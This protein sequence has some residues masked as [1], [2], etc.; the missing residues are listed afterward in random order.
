MKFTVLMPVHDAIGLNIFK[1][2]INSVINNILV[3]SEFLIIVDGK[4][5]LKKRLFLLKEKKRNKFI[6]VIFKKKL[7][8]VKILNFGLKI[9]K[10]NLVARADADDL[11]HKNRFLE[12]VNFF[13]KNKVDILGSNINEIINRKKFIKKVPT[14]P[15][16]LH[17]CFINPINHN[18]VMFRKDKIMRLGS[19]PNIKY[20]EDY[21]LWFLAKLSGYIVRNLDINLVNSVFDINKMIRR[22]NLKAIYS[23][24]VI[25]FFIL[26]KNILLIFIL[27]FSFLL[28][29]FSLMLPAH[30]FL[31]FLKKI[32]R[33]NN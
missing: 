24:L 10:Y 1:K 20:K 21:A 32:N 15:S 7:G 14:R 6:N 33:F 8:L 27:P 22:K 9:A 3:P 2:S 30:F 25:F 17:F 26:K 16:L 29:I 28:R 18:T 13:K 23:E 31:F 11:N 12:Q 19:Y 5:S 4:I